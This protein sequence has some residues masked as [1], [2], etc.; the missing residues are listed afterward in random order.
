MAGALAQYIDALMANAR[1]AQD[2]LSAQLTSRMQEISV[3]LNLMGEQQLLSDRAKAVAFREKDRDALRRAIREEMSNK[4]WEAALVLAHD[5]EASFGY[6]QEAIRFREEVAALRQEDIRKAIAEGVGV[7][8]RHC[9]G[10]LWADAQREAERLMQLYPDQPQAQ[11]LPKEIE[12]RRQL[13]KQQLTDSWH[14]AV[15]RKD[16]DGA[17]EILKKLDIYL[18]PAEAETMQETARSVFKAKLDSLKGQFTAAVQDHN[19]TEA[20]RLGEMISRDFP[21]TRLAQEVRD[22]ME[23]LRGRA[24]MAEPATV[25]G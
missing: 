3:L 21:N 11:Q 19:W 23:A 2:D 5:M 25:A 15:A 22:T 12:Q 6:R 8:D 10:E 20:V 17:I 4:D 9:R 16:V 18:T 13:H 24:G 1:K 14:E 7:I